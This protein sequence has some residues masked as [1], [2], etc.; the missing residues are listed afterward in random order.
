MGATNTD[1][2]TI[3]IILK[4]E[5]EVDTGGHGLKMVRLASEGEVGHA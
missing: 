2:L 1:Y 4:W 5:E 3:M